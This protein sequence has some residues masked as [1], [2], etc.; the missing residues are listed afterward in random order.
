MAVR[1]FDLVTNGMV[2]L[3]DLPNHGM[4]QDT[5][6]FLLKFRGML[7]GKSL[8]GGEFLIVQYG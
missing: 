1:E 5:L 6:N 4:T 7:G 3:A 8:E 2:P